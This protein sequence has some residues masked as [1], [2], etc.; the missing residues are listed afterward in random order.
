[1]KGVYLIW[2]NEHAAWWGPNRRG[3]TTSIGAAGRY[4]A[5]EAKAI[6]EQANGHLRPEDELREVPV[7][8]PEAL[9]PMREIGR[10]LHAQDNRITDQPLFIVQRKRRVTGL[11]PN[12]TDSVVWLSA[13]EGVEADAEEAG[14]LEAK[15][16]ETLEEPED[17]IRTGF[18]DEWVYV[19]GC[20]T[21]QGCK[22]YLAANGHNLGET[23]IYAD[24][25]YRN[26][27]YRAV[28]DFLMAIA[29]GG[30]A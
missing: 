7:L 1:M 28:R 15:Y 3:Y 19:T 10:R 12:Y 2:S 9:V 20:F 16:Q 27:E 21:E 18:R 17:W 6:F 13:D 30:R 5:D 8:A 4:S 26:G 14:R 23:R 25:S 11:D 24:G 29:D 22:D